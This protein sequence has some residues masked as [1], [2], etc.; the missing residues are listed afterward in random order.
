MLEFHGLRSSIP[1]PSPLVV[2]TTLVLG[3]LAIFGLIWVYFDVEALRGWLG[4]LGPWAAAAYLLAFV[5][6]TPTLVPDTPLAAIAGAAFGVFWGTVLSLGG[7]TLAAALI[8]VLSRWLLRDWLQGLLAHHPRLATVQQVVVHGRRRLLVLLRLVPIN[9][10]LVSYLLAA[11]PIHFG[12]YLMSCVGL[13]PAYFAAAYLGWLASVS[14]G[15]ERAVG[16][17]DYVATAG[18]VAT[19]V[20]LLVAARTA[21]ATW[22]DFTPRRPR[23]TPGE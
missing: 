18:F 3:F 14:H 15:S 21:R 20:A 22:R 4:A 17:G 1:P 11:T 8:F 5:L 19:V 7:A 2:R 6:I 16:W 23:P 12:R 9:P 13:L 10:A